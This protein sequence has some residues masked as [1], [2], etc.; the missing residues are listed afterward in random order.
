MELEPFG[1]VVFVAG[2]CILFVDYRWAI[3]IGFACTVFGAAGAV[4]LPV[5]GGATITPPHLFSVFLI[6]KA[7][8]QQNGIASIFDALSL[9]KP[10]GLLAIVIFYGIF[11]SLVAPS[12]FPEVLVYAFGRSENGTNVRLEPLTYGSGQ[13]TQSVY[14]LGDVL[15]F[16]CGTIL[17]ARPGAA[18]HVLHA[19]VACAV[20]NL[21]F[22]VADLIS[23]YAGHP[24]F[25]SFIR[26][27]GYAQLY[28]NVEGGMKRIVGSF[29]ETS[30]FSAYS[31]ALLG[32][33]TSLWMQHYRPRLS[34]LL[35]LAT[36]IAMA[37]STSS[38]AYVA[39]GV[40]LS[41]F[42]ASDIFAVLL[43][44]KPRR[45]VFIVVATPL[46]LFT[47]LAIILAK[48][49]IIDAVITVL[50][51]TVFNKASTASGIERFAWNSRAWEGFL[52]TNGIGI[53]IGG[54]R[55]SSYPLILLS[56]VGLLGTLGFGAFVYKVLSR[57]NFYPADDDERAIGIACRWAFAASLIA[58]SISAGVFE[59]G[60]LPYLSASAAAAIGIKEFSAKRR[61]R[62][63]RPTDQITATPG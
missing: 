6:L 53:G 45:L 25:L 44:R 58:S 15:L 31:C 37:F 12:L 48:P 55:A 60:V 20:L 54:G 33:F 36:L 51:E 10:G 41:F 35:A 7:L 9:R 32:F 1:L 16:A 34:G 43:N 39:I 17:T 28:N 14:A 21:T 61:M 19:F 42:V 22:A 27:G 49:G 57:R 26:T 24:E 18:R 52:D 13:I 2:L 4:S 63:D 29:T 50:D 59:L 38:T 46:V 47:L 8:W 5:L 30:S 62:L 23:F 11:V 56:N 3:F 40:L